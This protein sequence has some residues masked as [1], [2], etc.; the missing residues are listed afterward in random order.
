MDDYPEIWDLTGFVRGHY[1]GPSP[2]F[3]SSIDGLEVTDFHCR[4][5][6]QL[7]LGEGTQL[8]LQIHYS[9]QTAFCEEVCRITAIAQE[10]T[11]LFEGTDFV[12]YSNK[13]GVEYASEYVL[14][15]EDSQTINYLYL[16]SLP[17]EEIEL[18]EKYIPKGYSDY[19]DII[20]SIG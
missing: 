12:A 11:D 20:F 4:Y 18:D 10:C 13:M 5:D 15:E 2:L 14:V 16:Q 8:L 17:I 1:G 3:P 19:G 6:E 9:D 7:P